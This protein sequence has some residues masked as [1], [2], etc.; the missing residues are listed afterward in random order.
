MSNFRIKKK[1]KK[2]SKMKESTTLD[3]KHRQKV[4]YF[5]NKK[6][7]AKKINIEL[8]KISNELKILD[9]KRENF[10]INDLE[11]RA[12]LLNR[13]DFLLEELKSIKNNYEEMN[14]YDKAGDLIKDYYEI[15]D[16]KTS[17]IKKKKTILECFNTTTENDTKDKNRA[18]LFE[19]FCQRVEGIRIHADDGKN[20]IKYC[21][22]C[23]IEK[24]LDQSESSYTCPQCGD[25]EIIIIDEDRQIK[26]YSPY[27]RLNHFREWLNQ[28]QAKESTDISEIVYYDIIREINK[29]RINNLTELTRERTQSML[30]KLGYNHL[31]EH[32]PY[33]INKLSNLPP[34]KLNRD[35]EKKFLRMFTMIQE[36][37][38]MY[39]PKGR[40]NFL[41][42]SYILYKFCELLELDHLLEFFPLLKSNDKIMEQDVVWKKFCNHLNWEFYPTDK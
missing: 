12:N 6:K 18:N 7:S 25:M 33:I 10:D 26:E 2:R 30:K 37:W 5:E 15:R 28:F 31:Y 36:P 19:R 42:Y 34:P 20:R 3:K 11:H 4:K 27:K 29:N 23:H 35:T 16:N 24:K 41:S 38:E 1:G 32:I 13:K 14:Y 9:K 21:N 22:Y 40:K 39:K 17:V 8:T